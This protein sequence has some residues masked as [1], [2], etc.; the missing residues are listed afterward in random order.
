MDW[1]LED[2]AYLISGVICGLNNFQ[3]TDMKHNRKQNTKE[4]IERTFLRNKKIGFTLVELLV[5]IAIISVLAG[6]L[7]PVL[8]NAVGS[9]RTIQC[10]S[11]FRQLGLASSEYYNDYN[12]SFAY[13]AYYFKD[14]SNTTHRLIWKDALKPYVEDVTDDLGRIGAFENPSSGSPRSNYACP[15]VDAR[16]IDDSRFNYRA[17]VGASNYGG[18]VSAKIFN[19]L[20]NYSFDYPSRLI[21]MGDAYGQLISSNIIT[22]S[23]NQMRMWHAGG[24]NILYRDLHVDLRMRGT[25]TEGVKSP[26]WDPFPTVISSD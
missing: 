14:E 21:F 17:T 1:A 15:E 13:Y 11:N 26:F 20:K 24:A 7:L 9:A 5:V 19:V 10:S 25:F 4:T 18:N 23:A 16:Y 2:M 3:V 12:S 8:E 22:E 6:M